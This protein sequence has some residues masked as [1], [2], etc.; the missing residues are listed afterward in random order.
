MNIFRY[1][2]RKI[3]IRWRDHR[4]VYL[5]AHD[6]TGNELLNDPIVRKRQL[7]INRWREPL[8]K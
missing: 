4:V 2:M 7:E 6:I 8:I 5:V 3:L 1:I